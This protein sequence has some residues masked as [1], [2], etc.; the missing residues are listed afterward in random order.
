MLNRIK[1]FLSFTAAF[2]LMVCMLGMPASVRAED[3]VDVLKLREGA[4]YDL[5]QYVMVVETPNRDKGIY[6][7]LGE[8]TS[9]KAV[10]LA[11][12]KFKQN[13]GGYWLLFR[14]KNL[15]TLRSSWYIDFGRY[16]EGTLGV[17]NIVAMFSSDNFD[18]HILIDGRHVNNKKHLEGQRGNAVPVYMPY[19]TVKTFGFY[20]E[21]LKGFPFSISP[22]MVEK[23]AY[24]IKHR[25]SDMD[26]A[27]LNLIIIAL[28]AVSFSLYL[29]WQRPSQFL[30]SV[31][32]VLFLAVYNVSDEIISYGNN[33]IAAYLDMIFV[34]QLIISIFMTRYV[35]SP[36]KSESDNNNVGF[37]VMASVIG[38]ALVF[39]ARFDYDLREYSDLAVF[40][41][42][43]LIIPAWIIFKTFF[44]FGGDIKKIDLIG[45]MTAWIILIAG[46]ISCETGECSLK[47]FG[48]SIYMVANLAHL[49]VLYMFTLDIVSYKKKIIERRKRQKL[50]RIE[51]EEELK[52][53]YEM[54]SRNRILDIMQSEKDLLMDL[55][56]HEHEKL[57]EVNEVNL[58][59]I[60]FLATVSHE[61]RTPMTGIMALINLMSNTHLSDMQREYI[62]TMQKTGNT[63]LSMLNNIL[64]L[65]KAESGNIQ[66]EKV[67]FNLKEAVQNIFDIMEHFAK[68]KKLDFQIRFDEAAPEVVR[69][70]PTRLS[71][72]LTNLINNAIKF[73]NNGYVRIDVKY[74]GA[75]DEKHQILFSVEDTGIGIAEENRDNVFKPYIQAD[76]SVT[77][78]FGGTGLGL[79]ICQHLV[80]MMGGNIDFKSQEGK[81]TVFFFNMTF[82]KEQE[83]QGESSTLCSVKATSD[84][85]KSIN[86]LVVD[87]NEVNRKLIAMVIGNGLGR[88]VTA[89]SATEALNAMDKEYFDAV[90]MDLEMPD[91]DGIVAT[92]M[93]RRIS[94]RKKCKVP[95]IAMTAHTDDAVVSRCIQAG[96]NDYIGK[97][98]DEVKLEK[99]INGIVEHKKSGKGFSAEE[100]LPCSVKDEGTGIEEIKTVSELEAG[101]EFEIDFSHQSLNDEI[102][103]EIRKKML[104][105]AFQ[106]IIKDVYFSIDKELS[107]LNDAIKTGDMKVIYSSSHTICGVAANFGFDALSHM[108]RKIQK[109]AKD[110]DEIDIVSK[111]VK[112]LEKIY[113]DTKHEVEKR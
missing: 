33:T 43:S 35:L 30:L 105:D 76:A 34:A 85:K 45:F 14:V 38:V 84:E 111:Y 37:A 36:V 9:G 61:I 20:I 101:K 107:V 98:I 19:D 28:I 95:I 70:D 102:F 89:G 8:Y 66:M 77:R 57:S 68:D 29:K 40:R 93:I 24:E 18:K 16:T 64:D 15:D 12:Y 67:N 78:R 51:T 47:F 71:Q 73:T 63:L 109:H 13:G 90:F 58:A 32:T 60:N 86:V 74:I 42:L 104:P 26:L 11:D 59:K 4:S 1:P 91:F 112:I 99:I 110:N 106:R 56:K 108:A 6:E 27:F 31:Y 69:G 92:G 100:I 79:S 54:V 48:F 103:G 5:S 46:R 25:N 10:S 65:S 53:T 49:A 22:N 41:F 87:D 21:P 2:C 17:S 7:A 55:K 113:G 96:M 44:A 94:D 52:R 75:K 50:L 81:G 62:E 3:I 39:I 23:T 72:V 83:K 97:P 80:Q 88:V 82:D